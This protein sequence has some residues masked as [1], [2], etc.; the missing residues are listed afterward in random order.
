MRVRLL[1]PVTVDDAG[2][3]LPL[4][5]SMQRTVLALLALETGRVVP[6]DRL[7][8]VLWGETPPKD[9]HGLVQTYISRLRGVL[10]PI[11]AGIERRA[12]GYLLD[13]PAQDVDLHVFRGVLADAATTSDAGPL[14]EALALWHG[15]PLADLPASEQLDRLRAGL[16]E[17]RLTAWEECLDRELRGGRHKEIAADLLRLHEEQPLRERVLSLLLVALYRDGRRAEALQRYAAA[18]E[19]L[20][21][22]LGIDPTPEL[23]ELHAR[24]LRDEL[25]PPAPATPVI[26]S[27]PRSLPYDVRDFTGREADLDR[28]RAA[29]DATGSVAICTVDGMGGIGKTTLAVH[30]AHQLA[31]RYPDGQLFVDLRGFTPGCGPAEPA[32]ALSILLRAM[33]VVDGRIPAGLTERAALW[34]HTVAGKR[35]LLLLDNVARADQARPLIPGTPGS[36]VLVT[37]RRRLTLDGAAGVSLG[38]LDHAGARALFT[39]I[40]GGRVTAEP[41][42]L[43]EVLVLCD[44][45]PLAI[46]IAAARLAHRT[47]WSVA[48]LAAR[49]RTER[50][51]LAELR[52]ADHDV[53]ATLQ[54]S[55]LD[56]TADQQRLLRLLGAHEG[57]DFTAY[58]VAAMTGTDPLDAERLLDELFDAHLLIQHAAGRYRFHDL[59][60]AFARELA[61]ETERRAARRELAGYYRQAASAAMNLYAPAER[62]FRPDFT[63]GPHHVP[64]MAD[65]TEALHWLDAERAN[66]VAVAH[67]APGDFSRLLF[68]YIDARSLHDAGHTVH[69]LALTDPDPTVQAHAHNGLGNLC[70]RRGDYAGAQDHL[71][72]CIDLLRTTGDRHNESRVLL[73]LGIVVARLGH[74]ELA[75]EYYR[76]S[77][78]IAVEFGDVLSEARSLINI[79]NAYRQ[80]GRYDEAAAAQLQALRKARQ[81]GAYANVGFS[82]FNLGLISLDQE[83]PDSAITYLDEALTVLR[84]VG[85]RS[86]EAGVIDSI[87]RALSL[88]GRHD[89]ALAHHRRALDLARETGNRHDQQ[90]IL[91]SLGETSTVHGHFATALDHHAEAL[92]LATTINAPDG[93]ARA[94][95]GQGRALLALGCREE[96]RQRLEQALT[97][98]KSLGFGRREQVEQLIKSAS[99]D[100]SPPEPAQRP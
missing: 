77:H 15:E 27:V 85:D 46:R 80:L 25:D 91:N 53:R 72:R 62:P 32:E 100:L 26:T 63:A 50:G 51:R 41:D 35:I 9:P 14:R 58:A 66:L 54:L 90:H 76:Q 67:D 61:P 33:G 93:Q 89:E 21:D 45:L 18:R 52:T 1:G 94:Y 99:D 64:P 36:L 5:S 37:S 79:G 34:R 23:V 3:A 20:A 59:M 38:S 12:H 73:N 84:E 31:D 48:H 6:V 88:Q 92:D 2:T 75:I 49:L 98:Y 82:L 24:I 65:A 40:A 55:Y 68:R 39:G 17:E 16:R 81:A 8:T 70:L 28:L 95:E 44:Y 22:D 97:L 30:L 60:Q 19:R 69:S 86:G 43:D 42:A 4:G 47:Q 56:L 10:K 13:L 29:A 7:I 57:Q 96:A 71:T 11:G 78:R 74:R 87:G 83:R